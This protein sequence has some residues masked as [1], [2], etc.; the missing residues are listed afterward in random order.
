[1]RYYAITGKP[2]LHSKSPELFRKA[3]PG[4]EDQQTYFR[5]AADSAAEARE[6]FS[7]LGL[8]GMNITSPFKPLENW[9]ADDV[10]D[11]AKQLEA[12]NTYFRKQDR[13]FF[14]NTDVDGVCGS[15]KSH[16]L[17][18]EGKKCL[19]VGA[20]GAAAA[21]A[22]ALHRAGG[23]VVVINR[24][25][26]R[27]EELARKIGCRFVSFDR[28]KE[29]VSRADVIVYTLYAGVD[30]IEE[31][32]LSPAQVVVDALYHGS[33]LRPKAI[34]KGCIY[35]GGEEWLIYQAVTGYRH[36]T[37]EEPDLNAMR[38][39]VNQ[40]ATPRHISLIGLM[41]V[42]KSTVGR[43]LAERLHCPFYDTDQLIEERCGMSVAQII[44]EKGE[45]VFREEERRLFD[46]L[47]EAAAGVISCGGGIVCNPF[48][49]EQLYQ[50]TVSVWL[51]ARPEICLGRIDPLTRPLLA[52]YESPLSGMKEL[53]EKRKPVYARSAWMLI[54]AN[55]RSA[56]DISEKI[57]EEIGHIN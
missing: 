2:V 27:A 55:F 1:M 25:P 23:E 4:K 21:A 33:T 24:T 26:G 36:F 15:L 28:L 34:K 39:P 42:G 56:E 29:A 19:V 45:A 13:S 30:V 6:L 51:Y 9:P 47:L 18:V 17:S 5:L 8:T 22:F 37:G 41:G 32:W 20:G 12:G 7:E 10:S 11:A 57:Y 3:Y 49:G 31:D 40:M 43:L 52:H 46:E 44:N 50:K 53:F 14:T 48:V 16:G 38:E 35:I 54:S